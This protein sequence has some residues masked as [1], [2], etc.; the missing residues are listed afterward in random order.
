M[1]GTTIS[2]ISVSSLAMHGIPFDTAAATGLLQALVSALLMNISIVGLNQVFDVEI[3]KVNKPYLPLASGDFSV[4]TGVILVAAT[5]CASLAVGAA[6]GSLP[7]MC[8]LLGSLVLGILYSIELPFMRWKKFPLLAAG[9][10]LVVRA[11]LVQ[12]G[13]Y[14]HMKQVRPGPVR[15]MLSF[16]NKPSEMLR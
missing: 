8:T 6:S 12:L 9:C 2:V 13:F 7:L 3:D 4:Q 16:H 11:V 14:F 10:I 15:G 5:A 1:L